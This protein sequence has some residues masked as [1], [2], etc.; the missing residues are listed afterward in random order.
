MMVIC[1]CLKYIAVSPPALYGGIMEMVCLILGDFLFLILKMNFR[2]SL[3][4][5]RD[6]PPWHRSQENRVKSIGLCRK[7]YI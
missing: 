3:S 4:E 2:R 7:C 6:E 1:R 5:Y